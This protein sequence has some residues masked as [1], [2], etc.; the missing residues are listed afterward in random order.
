MQCEERE[1]RD[2]RVCIQIY[3][4]LQCH[5]RSL[6]MRDALQK[7]QRLQ[8]ELKHLHRTTA[9]VIEESQRLIDDLDRGTPAARAPAK[10]MRRRGPPRGPRA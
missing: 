9:R 4:L 6:S 2:G 5:G 1:G 7:L 3:A 10:R 8:R